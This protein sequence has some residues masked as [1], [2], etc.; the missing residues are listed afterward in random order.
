MPRQRFE[1]AK[2]ILGILLDDDRA[3]C[4]AGLPTRPQEQLAKARGPFGC[5]SEVG[6]SEASS[7]VF[8]PRA[9]RLVKSLA[10]NLAE[11]IAG[12]QDKLV[13]S[14][15]P[16]SPSD[17]CVGLSPE[18]FTHPDAVGGGTRSDAHQLLMSL[19]VA[20]DLAD[21]E[22]SHIVVA[23]HHLLFS[24]DVPLAPETWRPLVVTAV[25]AAAWAVSSEDMF[26][27]IEQSILD[28]VA[29]WWPAEKAARGLLVFKNWEAFHRERMTLTDFTETYFKLRRQGLEC[30]DDDESM[31][32][33][34]PSS[35]T[36]RSRTSSEPRRGR[37]QRPSRDI[38]LDYSSSSTRSFDKSLI[39]NSHPVIAA[40]LSPEDEGSDGEG[41]DRRARARFFRER[42]CH[43][44]SSVGVALP[45][46]TSESSTRRG[47]SRYS[48]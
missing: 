18:V 44:D 15:L 34:N 43:A 1:D 28:T 9:N 35:I 4:R 47:R 48:L 27:Q 26:A 41:S 12:Q 10:K 8:R 33:A 14:R 22:A 46:Q 11:R 3:D 20:A 40:V 32:S 36:S 6:S 24:P 13:R 37:L 23:A 42:L 17:E 30:S 31:P 19:L 7:T 2:V 38:S 29:H 39:G 5:R 45:Y 21:R 25:L 16:S